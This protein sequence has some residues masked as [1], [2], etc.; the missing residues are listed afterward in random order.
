M[1]FEVVI[2][3][4]QGFLLFSSSLLT[5]FPISPLSSNPHQPH[6]FIPPHPLSHSHSSVSRGPIAP[7]L[8]QRPPCQSI[9]NITRITMCRDPQPQIPTRVHA[10]TVIDPAG[11]VPPA[12]AFEPAFSLPPRLHKPH[13]RRPHRVRRSRGTLADH[14]LDCGV[15]AWIHRRGV[16]VA[17]GGAIV[18]LHEPRVADAVVGGWHAD[19]ARRFLQ[20]DGED[21]ARVEVC[22]DR[23]KEGGVV[24]RLDFEGRVEGNVVDGAR[25]FD[26]GKIVLEPIEEK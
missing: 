1:V 20:D 11:P 2:I 10:P 16:L 25:V 22:F 14:L 4:A 18:V 24:D 15:R 6:P 26:Q 13:L 17:R 3:G 5:P 23:D 21:E 7:I 9:R 19:A 8:R 12:S